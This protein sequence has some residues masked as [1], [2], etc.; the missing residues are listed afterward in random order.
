MVSTR[1]QI[2]GF[3]LIEVLASMAVLLVVI[4]ALMRMFGDASLAYKK[5]MTTMSRNAA[6]RAALEMVT[7][8]VEGIVVD[9]RH[10]CYK[11]AN[12]VDTNYDEIYLVTTGGDQDDGRAYQLVHYYVSKDY[13]YYGLETGFLYRLMRA[14]CDLDVAYTNANVMISLNEASDVKDRR[15]W[16]KNLAWSSEVV[17]ENVVRFDI[18]LLDTNNN[19]IGAGY[20]DSCIDSNSYWGHNSYWSFEKWPNDVA[21]TYFDFYLQVTSDEAM[22][23]AGLVLK[24]S[25]GLSELARSELYR[26]SSVLIRRVA[27]LQNIQRKHPITY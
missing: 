22:K 24:E 14:T 6:A 26:D 10:A 9:N 19:N 15:W 27:P 21:P 23:K 8:D 16:K 4:L 3:T 5:G 20:F 17:I 11:I 12:V 25:P 13:A 2:T 18:Y 1:R 7:K